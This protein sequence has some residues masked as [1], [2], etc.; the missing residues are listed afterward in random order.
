MPEGVLMRIIQRNSHP[1]ILSFVQITADRVIRVSGNATRNSGR[2]VLER[3]RQSK[4]DEAAK[5]RVENLNG[6]D[7][8]KRSLFI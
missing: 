4:I 3:D 7:K 2:R 6:G 8:F 5:E 1:Q